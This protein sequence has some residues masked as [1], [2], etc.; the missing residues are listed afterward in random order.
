MSSI[1]CIAAGDISDEAK[2]WL[3]SHGAKIEDGAVALIDLP[4]N[5]L[6]EKQAYWWD[7][8]IAFYGPD[9][10]YEPQYCSVELA[11]NAYDTRVRLKT[12]K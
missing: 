9:G 7:H 5:A 1:K 2:A 10:E 8:T 3:V 6:L 12:D 4:E 11:V